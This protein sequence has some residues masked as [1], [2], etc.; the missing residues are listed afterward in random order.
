M[1]SI[2]MPFHKENSWLREA[3]DSCCKEL[4]K[5][6]GELLL[7]A[8]ST[9]ASRELIDFVASKKMNITVKTSPGKGIVDALNY[10]LSISEYEYIARMDSDDIMLTGRL[11]NQYLFLSN[12]PEISVVGGNIELISDTGESLGIIEYPSGT[13]LL[14][15]MEQGCFLAHP[16]VMFRKSVILK[17]GGYSKIFEYCEDYDLWDRVC[18]ISQIANVDRV[19]IQYRQH[20]SQT[21]LV[22]SKRQLSSTEAIILRKKIHAHK[23]KSPSWNP[24]NADEIS[25]WVE[26]TKVINNLKK[27][28]VQP[29]MKAVSEFLRRRN[30]RKKLQKISSIK[31]AVLIVLLKPSIIKKKLSTTISHRRKQSSLNLLH[32]DKNHHSNAIHVKLVGGFGNQLFQFFMALN[33]AIKNDRNLVIDDTYFD[34]NNLHEYTLKRYLV[35]NNALKKIPVVISFE[36][37]TKCRGAIH[38]LEKTFHW[39][40]INLNLE[41]C[42]TLEGY[43]Q[44]EK[45]FDHIAKFI[46]T[47]FGVRRKFE[48][49]TIHVRR[50]DMWENLESRRVHGHLGYDYYCSA[51]NLLP[52]DLPIRIVSDSTSLARELFKDFQG[53]IQFVESNSDVL[54]DFILLSESKFLIIA[55]STFSWWAGY[56]SEADTI[57]APRNWFA[58][59]YLRINNTCDLFPE[60]WI[61]C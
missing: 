32:Q 25:E 3:I 33:L 10:G 46:N 51:L 35:K 1:I 31:Y 53:N 21:S 2:V 37:E 59:E 26:E 5:I 47:E 30:S 41:K 12:H 28:Q 48:G 34:K 42:V 22:K 18:Q 13:E 60:Q 23:I 39:T 7:I 9:V 58:E 8:D 40:D 44:S 43:W 17:V 55:N 11:Q 54:G 27:D 52:P 6:D 16:A 50:G 19:L 15:K 24:L 57:I 29:Y 38:L 45:Y 4:L 61:L 20:A 36:S 56:L 14:N 49:I